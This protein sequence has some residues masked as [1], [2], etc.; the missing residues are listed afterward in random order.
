MKIELFSPS[1]SVC[2]SFA[3][4][5]NDI[6]SKNKNAGSLLIYIHQFFLFKIV[7]FIPT[8]YVVRV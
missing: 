6:R 4:Y 5:S 8:I 2:L 7:N 3:M 1:F